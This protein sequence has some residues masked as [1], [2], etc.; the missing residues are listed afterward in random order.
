IVGGA[1]PIAIACALR[2]HPR[3]LVVYLQ[4][5]DNKEESRM[6]T[7]PSLLLALAASVSA[8]CLG[9]AK[10][11]TATPGS[12]PATT[13]I[14]IEPIKIT[15]SGKGGEVKS[16]A[17]DA[18]SLFEEATDAFNRGDYATASKDFSRV[19]QE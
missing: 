5:R 15:A 1:L 16:E 19:Y 3:R 17:Y 12:S 11:K 18:K 4:R 13:I 10:P 2:E 6:R 8:G 14:E 9:H 7:R